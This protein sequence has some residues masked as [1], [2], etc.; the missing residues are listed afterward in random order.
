MP[1]LPDII[2]VVAIIDAIEFMPYATI[3]ILMP[4][5]R[6]YAYATPDVIF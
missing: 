6:H 1:L 3:M 4:M 5:L 2:V